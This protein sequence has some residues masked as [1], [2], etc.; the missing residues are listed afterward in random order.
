MFEGLIVA[1]KVIAGY[2]DLRE[3]FFDCFGT[4]VQM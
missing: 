3:S 4:S 2:N 1:V